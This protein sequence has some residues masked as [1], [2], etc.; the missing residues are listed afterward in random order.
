MRNF[1]AGMLLGTLATY[2]YLTHGGNIRASIADLWAEASS[3]PV[4]AARPHH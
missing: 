1:L 4:A 3:P 2:W